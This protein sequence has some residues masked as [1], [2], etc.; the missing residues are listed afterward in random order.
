MEGLNLAQETHDVMVTVCK[1]NRP[2]TPHQVRLAWNTSEGEPPVVVPHT[3]DLEDVT[4]AQLVQL[5]AARKSGA[6][7][8]V[9]FDG[10]VCQTVEVL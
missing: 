1:I 10:P 7:L 4:D 2:P 3:Q 5:A 8:R 6:T 9:T